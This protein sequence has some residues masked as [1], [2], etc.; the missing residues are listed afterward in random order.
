MRE[1]LIVGAPE[2]LRN[3]VPL[4]DSGA[5]T[6]SAAFIT[7]DQSA[8]VDGVVKIED[9]DRIEERFAAVLVVDLAG[10]GILPWFLELCMEIGT[11]GDIPLVVASPSMTATAIASAY[12]LGNAVASLSL[13]PGATEPQSYLEYSTALQ[14]T[15]SEVQLL[16]SE[17]ASLV[18]CTPVRVEDRVAHVSF[19]IL[20]MIINEAVFALQ[21]GVSDASDIDTAMKFG[22]NYPKGPLAW[23]DDIGAE[24][25][26]R[27]LDALQMEY[28]EERYRP[29]VLLRQ[30]ARAGKRFADSNDSR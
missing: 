2:E 15:D 20:A 7:E 22:T 26:V 17:L 9:L 18:G 13:I 10:Y 3:I 25:V 19:R 16:E 12:S 11:S 29:A 30:Y 23:C 14:S 4:L 1:V 5:N 6:F 27:A 21:E 8:I 24:V 28:G